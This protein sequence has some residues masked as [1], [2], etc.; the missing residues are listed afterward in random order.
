M[1]KG[2]LAGMILMLGISSFGFSA[3]RDNYEFSKNKNNTAR[4]NNFRTVLFDKLKLKLI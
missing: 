1:K 4:E 3:G 2:I